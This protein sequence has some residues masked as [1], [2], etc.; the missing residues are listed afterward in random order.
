MELPNETDVLVVGGGG[1]GLAT[2]VAAAYTGA[3]VALLEK[4]PTLGGST[5]LSVGSFCAA[6]TR[7]QR[8]RGLADSITAF[9][10]DMAAF[11][12]R[13]IARDAPGL[14]ATLAAAAG[15]TLGWLERH[16]VAFAGPFPEPPNRVPRMHNVVPYARSYIARLS[17]AASRLGVRV[18]TG[19]R[20][21]RL[22]VTA[23]GRVAGA[24]VRHD[25]FASRLVARRGVVLATGDFAG[26]AELRRR[27]LS[28]AAA[29]ATPINPANTGDGHLLAAEAGAAWRNMDVIFGP[30]LRFPPPG[31]TLV[32][33]LPSWRWLAALGAAYVNRAPRA[34]LR[35]LVKSVLITHTSPSARLFAEGAVL[36]NLEGRRFAEERESTAELAFQPEGSGY[37]VLDQPLADLFSR[38]PYFI[39]TAPG[40][41]YAYFQDYAAARPDVVHRAPDITTLARTLTLQPEALAASFA[42]TGRAW[43]PPFY[44]LG[45]VRSMLTVTEGGIAIDPDCRVLRANGSVIEGLYAAGGAGQGGMQLYGHGLHIAWAFTSGRLAGQAAARATP[46]DSAS[47]PAPIGAGDG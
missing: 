42:E 22:L 16:G 28:P 33:R 21:E 24:I 31:G 44:A 12:P 40:I 19:A 17:E 36:V 30:Q 2:A 35:P 37:I 20:A 29:A 9:V 13:L 46:V 47:L 14:R 26:S 3:R 1:A 18:V 23:S 41:A 10:E 15:E 7:L 43:R 25:G 8:R 6:G 39:S 4:Q 5:A 38:Y 34:L 27:F 45:P 32:E 11:D